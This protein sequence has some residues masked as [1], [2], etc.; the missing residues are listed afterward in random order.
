MSRKPPSA[1]CD[2]RI[3]GRFE[4]LSVDLAEDRTLAEVLRTDRDRRAVGHLAA[5]GRAGRCGRVGRRGESAG[6]A[7][8]AVG[9]RPRDAVVVAAA[10]GERE[11]Q[12]Q[13][14]ECGN[15]EAGGS[16][17]RARFVVGTGV[18]LTVVGGA[19][20]RR[21]VRVDRGADR[22][23]APTPR[24][25]SPR[26]APPADPSVPGPGRRRCTCRGTRS[27]RAR[28]ASPWRRSAPR[29]PHTGHQQRDRGRQFDLAQHLAAAHPDAGRGL[30][31]ARAVSPSPPHTRS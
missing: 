17:E 9:V 14:G 12:G 23:S 8:P 5:R 4:R 3:P 28:R 2:D 10:G 26:R 20:E 29:H 16:H 7:L 1:C 27:R 11:R 31:D 13:H 18:A 6:A 15:A 22:R 25:G 24:P 30:D 19:T 21:P